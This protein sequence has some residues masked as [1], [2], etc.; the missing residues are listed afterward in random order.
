[1]WYRKWMKVLMGDDTKQC[2]VAI[3]DVTYLWYVAYM[4][5]S[6]IMA[7]LINA[8]IDKIWSYWLIKMSND[9]LKKKKEVNDGIQNNLTKM[10]LWS[11]WTK[12]QKDHEKK[13]LLIFSIKKAMISYNAYFQSWIL[14]MY[15][16]YELIFSIKWF[17]I[18]RNYVDSFTFNM[19][20][21]MIRLF[22][23][24]LPRLYL[25][26]SFSIFVL[27]SLLVLRMIDE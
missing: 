10:T 8:Q 19:S 13:N 16:T 26:I 11:S 12:G 2:H 1:M 18:M 5:L 27:F 20:Q 23:L 25:S 24:F 21:L 9:P 17:V 7:N 3:Q 4:I 6:K 22:D 14:L 15:K